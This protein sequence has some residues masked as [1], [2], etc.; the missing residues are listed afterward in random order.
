MAGCLTVRGP[1]HDRAGV[2][3]VLGDRAQLAVEVLRGASQQL[4]G[5]IG[6]DPFTLLQDALCLADDLP[7]RQGRVEVLDAFLVGLLSLGE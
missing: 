5:L 2:D 3:K 1:R 4:E 7:R 6:G